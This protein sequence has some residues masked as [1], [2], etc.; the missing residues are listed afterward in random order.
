MSKP[1]EIQR[2]VIEGRGD[3][4]HLLV[5]GG[6]HGDE[7]EPM[8]AVRRLI[9]SVD[10]A[11]LRGKLTAVPAVNE[12]AFRN[13]DRWAEDELDLARVCPGDPNGSVTMRTAHALSELI[14]TADYYIDLH[15]GGT[16]L[17]V[18]PMSGY[19]LHDDAGVLET[20]RQMAQAFNLPLIWGT[21]G[22][23][24]G[25]SL[26]IARDAMVP[27]IYTEYH[28]S[29]VCDPQGVVDY[30]DGCLNVMGWLNMIDRERP[31]SRVEHVVED[32]RDNAG[33][34]QLQ[35]RSPVEG[36]FEP[37]VTLGQRVKAGDPIG[38]VS[39]VLGDRVETVRS[40]QDG[41]V[42][43][44]KTFSRVDEGDS[45]GVIVEADRPLG[46]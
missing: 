1:I 34:M 38:R 17:T 46:G 6:V 9:R 40:H 8:A 12:A 13:K 11:K 16:T 2:K 7:F 25:R 37:A 20:Q 36:F 30:T 3:G 18:I 28:G 14:R 4:P 22:K 27:A 10:P 43:T 33:H 45:V 26:S 21:Q 44:L 32:E 35:N 15:T 24:D 42:L 39:D 31:P 29:A 41:I 19:S 23:L 5:T